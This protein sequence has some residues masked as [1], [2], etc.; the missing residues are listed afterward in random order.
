MHTPV[1]ESMLPTKRATKPRPTAEQVRLN[2]TA[3]NTV[4]DLPTSIARMLA[5]SERPE[6][7]KLAD[8]MAHQ[9]YR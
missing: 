7:R 2:R 3:K 9:R 1:L 6:L 8:T 5:R 4:H